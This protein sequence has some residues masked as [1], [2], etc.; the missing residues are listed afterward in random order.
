MQ[1]IYLLDSDF[2]SYDMVVLWM[3]L[4]YSIENAYY[5]DTMIVFTRIDSIDITNNVFTLASS[6]HYAKMSS[7]ILI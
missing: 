6:S 5:K 4:I 1:I 2:I 3:F 7:L